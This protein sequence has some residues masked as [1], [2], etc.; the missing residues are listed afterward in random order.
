MEIELTNKYAITKADINYMA[1]DLKDQLENGDLDP[2]LL[3]QKFKAVEKIHEAI[4]PVLTELAITQAKKYPEKEVALYGASYTVKEAG[5]T[6]DYSN[7]GDNKYKNLLAQAE[8]LKKEIKKREDFLKGIVG[9]ET[10]VDE[11]T[12]EILKV[13]PPVK[14][15]TTVVQVSIK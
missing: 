12:S 1:G 4:K 3:L 15:S 10:I 2:L 11:D 7:C 9:H 8:E 5:T 13:F 14:K 6:Y